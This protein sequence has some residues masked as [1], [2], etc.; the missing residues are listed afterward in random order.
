MYRVLVVV[1]FSC[2][3]LVDLVFLFVFLILFYLFFLSWKLLDTPS[4]KV[5]ET[6]HASCVSSSSVPLKKQLF[7]PKQKPPVMTLLQNWHSDTAAVCKRRSHLS[8]ASSR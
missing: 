7:P 8:F 4:P 1:F 2:F 3:L 6:T 5:A